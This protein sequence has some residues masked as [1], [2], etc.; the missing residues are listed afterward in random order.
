MPYTEFRKSYGD[1]EVVIPPVDFS[2]LTRDEARLTVIALNCYDQHFVCLTLQLRR[3]CRAARLI[4]DM[5][6]QTSEGLCHSIGSLVE[7]QLNSHD[8]ETI[9]F[10][11]A[12]THQGTVL[13]KAWCNHMADEIEREFA[14]T[15][16]VT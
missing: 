3:A 15:S 8:D 1:F 7:Q 11:G 13:R 10:F 2:S 4:N 14:L 5:I 12:T 6:D 9:P 16:K